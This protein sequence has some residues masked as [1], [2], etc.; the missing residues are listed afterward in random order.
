MKRLLVGTA[1]SGLSA[2]RIWLVQTAQHEGS[3]WNSDVA[4]YF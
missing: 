1:I 2:Y 4:R 3:E